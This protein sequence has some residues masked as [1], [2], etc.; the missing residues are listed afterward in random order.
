MATYKYL[1]KNNTGQTIQ[2]T[3]SAKDQTEALSELRRKNLVVLQVS[4]AAA[5]SKPGGRQA[6]RRGLLGL[7]L[8]RAGVRAGAGVKKDELV[9]FARQLAT[10]ISAGIPLL[11]SL[12]ILSE[13]AD[14]IGF[15]KCL[16]DIVQEIRG[17]KDLSQ[18]LEKYPRVFS[19]IF[20]SMIRAGEA[21]GQLDEI[22]A[23]LADY[24]EATQKLK[25]DVRAAMTYPVI[26]LVL[27]LGITSFLMVGIVPK[28]QE[29]FSSLEIDMPALT[30]TVLEVSLWLKDHWF[31]GAGA[32]FGAFV[33]F[34]LYK[35]TPLGARQTD[36]LK[37]YVPVFGPLFRKVA[38]SRFARTFATLIKSGVPILGSLEIVSATAGNR[39]IS[40]VVDR[41]RENV[42]Q[43]DAL[44][45]PLAQ[46]SV[47]PPMVTRMIGIG[48]KSGSL[49]TLL[50]K[51]ATFY[52]EQV[53]AE[54]KSL[55]SLIEP[56]LIGV[57]GFL[58]GGIVLAVFLPI[59]ELQ[60]KLATR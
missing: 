35:K 23:R 55:T 9:L 38:L 34:G 29:V 39:V 11:E 48:E 6:R 19:N 28:F 12:E 10:M 57:M 16:E 20:V 59:F 56:I 51:I 21:S 32:A 2:G 3:V 36:W 44:S 27:V 24:M 49:E 43:G 13:Q 47:F 53:A 37:L 41:A 25:R 7:S 60:K 45:E 17:G 14:S 33:L 5:S 58:V 40:A 18:C 50:E 46:S 54:V 1:A 42:R 22:L 26:S 31:V 15:K 52:D 4:Q 30:A 8:T